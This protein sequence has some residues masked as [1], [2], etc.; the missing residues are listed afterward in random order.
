MHYS[1]LEK[2]AAQFEADGF[3][4]HDRSADELLENV[5][6]AYLAGELQVPFTLTNPPAPVDI[7]PA[8]PKVGSHWE[9]AEGDGDCGTVHAVRDGL[10][11]FQCQDSRWCLDVL[12]V[13]NFHRRFKPAE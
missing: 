10:V 12:T 4:G 8:M 9:D 11:F 13:A 2:L 7:G 1:E 6:R 5:A 3:D